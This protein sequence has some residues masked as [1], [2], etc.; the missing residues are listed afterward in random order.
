MYSCSVS[1]F[2]DG[3]SNLKAGCKK[4]A[5]YDA[6]DAIYMSCIHNRSSN[7]FMQFF[8]P[9]SGN[10]RHCPLFTSGTSGTLYARPARTEMDG[11]TVKGSFSR[12]YLGV[13]AYSRSSAAR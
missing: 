10:G 9:L 11:A 5:V 7:F 2:L 13:L 6:F 8:S 12:G 1:Q 3:S 4:D